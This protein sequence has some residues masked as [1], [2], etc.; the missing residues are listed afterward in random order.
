MGIFA[1]MSLPNQTAI[2][3]FALHPVSLSYTLN[4]HCTHFG[5]TLEFFCFMIDAVV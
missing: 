5:I 3:Y 1:Y 2:L 4:N